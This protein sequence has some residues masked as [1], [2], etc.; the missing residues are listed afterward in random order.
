[1][2]AEEAVKTDD[3]SSRGFDSQNPNNG[4]QNCVTPPTQ[5]SEFSSGL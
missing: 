4:L 5:D 1:M 2:G 3:C